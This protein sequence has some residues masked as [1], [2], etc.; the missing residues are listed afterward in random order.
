MENKQKWKHISFITG[1]PLDD[2]L[3]EYENRG[4][5]LV[6]IQFEKPPYRYIWKRPIVDS[7]LSNV[8]YVQ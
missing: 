8:A 2:V 6:T 1:D 5:E 7:V 3:K 4:W